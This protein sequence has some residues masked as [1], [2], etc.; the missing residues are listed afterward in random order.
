MHAEMAEA[1]KAGKTI[2]GHYA[3]PDLGLP[4]HGYVAGGPEDD[5]EGT[6]LQDAVARVRQGMKAM[7]R[8]GSGW[9]DVAAQIE[10]VTRLGLDPRR[11]I[12]CTDDS[13]SETL[14][15]EGH[16]NRAIKED[17]SHGLDPLKA[18][19]MAT[20]NP[21]EHFGV[22]RDVG[23]IAPGRFGD[24]LILSELADLTVD[25]VISKGTVIAENGELTI[26]LPSFPYPSWVLNSVNLGHPLQAKDFR[27]KTPGE[28]QYLA[29]IIG[30]I[31]N[32]APTK[33][34]KLTV[35]VK[36]GEIN[37]AISRDIAK[38]A[39]VERHRATGE[40]QIGLVSGFGLNVPCAIGTTVAHDS[41]QMI[42][43][44]TSDADMA[45]AANELARIG[46]GQVVIRDGKVFGRVELPIAGLMSM[47]HAEIVARKAGTVLDGFKACG[48]TLNNPNM[49]LSLL[50]LVVIPELRISDL[51]L[52]DVNRF[53]FIPLFEK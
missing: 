28:G 21:A 50:A 4:F 2:G 17:I 51:G 29:N 6:R 8:M 34:L 53:E 15:C 27:L 14:V 41:H 25:V 32:Q 44:G 37:S 40:V 13:H 12:L 38:I 9:H 46:G 1:R 36:N 7:L 3:S 35:E 45:I 42:I 48:C 26:D 11:F 18:I 49:Q 23:M 19:Q 31:E 43:V 5:H 22:T 52:V 39:V 20:I 47:E 33:H 24:V 10:A 30:I 16:V